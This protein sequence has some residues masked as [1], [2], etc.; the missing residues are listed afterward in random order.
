MIDPNT[1][2]GTGLDIA[3]AVAVALILLAV[4]VHYSRRRSE[5]RAGVQHK[6]NPWKGPYAPADPPPIIYQHRDK[7]A[8]G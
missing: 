5:R 1:V 7:S 6:G 4:A 2:A 8:G 3:F